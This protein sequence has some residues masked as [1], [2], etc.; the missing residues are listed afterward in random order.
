MEHIFYSH[1]DFDHTMG[2]RVIE[3]LKMDW[4]AGL[5]GKKQED[6][7]EVASLSAILKDVKQ[8]GTKDCWGYSKRRFRIEGRQPAARGT[9]YVRRD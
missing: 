8:Q 2:M 7:I 5:V 4:L 9:V 1:C 3:Q 6:P